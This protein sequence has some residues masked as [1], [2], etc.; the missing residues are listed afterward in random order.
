MNDSIREK[1]N[2]IKGDYNKNFTIFAA[3]KSPG[4]GIGRHATLRG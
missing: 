3:L 2:R 1:K 4:G